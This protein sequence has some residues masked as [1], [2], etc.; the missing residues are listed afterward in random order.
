MKTTK[1]SQKS[2][3]ES[4]LQ[5]KVA[6]HP[7]KRVQCWGHTLHTSHE[8]C[9]YAVRQPVGVCARHQWHADF[10][11]WLHPACQPWQLE[12]LACPETGTGKHSWNRHQQNSARY[13]GWIPAGQHPAS[14]QTATDDNRITK[15]LLNITYT[16]SNKTTVYPHRFTCP[17]YLY[18]KSHTALR[19]PEHT[20]FGGNLS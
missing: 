9:S 3:V 13:R 16:C 20:L 14:V 17:Q 11:R 2:P 5:R 1:K 8:R 6:Y 4:C 12:S 7:G 19:N 10:S 15:L 18:H